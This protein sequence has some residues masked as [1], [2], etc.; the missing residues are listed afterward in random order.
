MMDEMRFDGRVA[1]ITGAGRGLGR[2]YAELLA[3][4]GAKVVVNDTGA[5]LNGGGE[6]DSPARSV[7]DAIEAAGG[8]A[9]MC[10]ASVAKPEGGAAIAQAALDRWGRIDIVIHNAGIVRRAS[11]MHMAKADLDQSLDVHLH[12]GFHIVRA[13]MPAMAEAGYGR[14]VLTG[15]CSGLYGNHLSANYAMGKMGLVGLCNVVALEGESAGIRCNM[16]APA[17]V[18]RMSEGIDTSQFPPMD[19]NL[20]APMVGWLSH[21]ACDVTGEIYIA[22]AGRMARAFI[23]ESRGAF[24]REWTLEQVA[25]A[26]PT[27]RDTAQ[28]VSFE[29]VPTGQ[30]DHLRYSFAMAHEPYDD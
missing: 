29:V 14:I 10:T 13:A 2:A 1:V 21:E 9:V 25:A 28:A 11:L 20:V 30:L 22:A 26:M 3:G 18:T 8:E 4:R 15:S 24:R 6:D 12:G 7:V 19:P 17:A 23:S 27:I 16:I 5:A